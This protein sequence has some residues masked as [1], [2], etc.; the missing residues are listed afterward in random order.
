VGKQS[1]ATK[2]HILS[3]IKDLDIQADLVGLD[4]EGW[5]LRYHLKE[6]LMQLLSA[7][8]EYWRQRDR[9]N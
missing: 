3:R 9:Q 6:Q 2:D 4:E 7:E 8:E 1:R 5:A